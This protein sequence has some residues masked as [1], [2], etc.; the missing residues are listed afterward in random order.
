MPQISFIHVDRYFKDENQNEGWFTVSLEEW[1]RISDFTL[2]F[3]RDSNAGKYIVEMMNWWSN[4][5][6]NLLLH[7]DILTAVNSSVSFFLYYDM[8]CLILLYCD[9]WSFLTHTTH[10]AFLTHTTHEAHCLALIYNFPFIK[11]S[12]VR[13][14]CVWGLQICSCSLCHCW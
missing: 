3:T 14:F 13:N 4:E 1:V 12:I 5:Q 8:C 2:Q 11:I 9:Y 10:E 7:S 6:W